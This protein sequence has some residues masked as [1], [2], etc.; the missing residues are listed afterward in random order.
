[1][2]RMV[3]GGILF[4]GGLIGFLA[5]TITSIFMPWNYN[6]ITGMEGFLLGTGMMSPYVLFC[7]SAIAGFVICTIEVFKK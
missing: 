6:G 3:Y 5:L 4:F 1:M 2:K 7:I